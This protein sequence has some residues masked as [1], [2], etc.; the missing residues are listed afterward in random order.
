MAKKEVKKYE[1]EC[2]ICG[3]KYRSSRIDSR[4]CSNA[5]CRK[6]ASLQ[7]KTRKKEKEKEELKRRQEEEKRLKEKKAEEQRKEKEWK[8]FLKEYQELERVEREKKKHDTAIS[9]IVHALLE[10]AESREHEI[11]E[12]HERRQN[13]ISSLEKLF[14]QI[15]KI[16]EKHEELFYYKL[17]LGTEFKSLKRKLIEYYD[18][19]GTLDGFYYL[20]PIYDNNENPI[21]VIPWIKA[22]E[23]DPNGMMAIC[24]AKIA[25]SF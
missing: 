11:K 12:K 25:T 16:E 19:N 24:I 5:N 13:A 14:Y 4:Y 22:V 7:G 15:S 18:T 3:K 8:S 6:K 10:N 17:Y 21:I 1:K 2:I 20:Q 9:H 23:A